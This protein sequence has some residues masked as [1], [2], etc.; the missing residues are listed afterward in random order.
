MSIISIEIIEIKC[1]KIRLCSHVIETRSPDTRVLLFSRSAQCPLPTTTTFLPSDFV[2]PFYN[3]PQTDARDDQQATFRRIQCS[4]LCTNFTRYKPPWSPQ[5]PSDPSEDNPICSQAA[6][7]SF[8]SVD[9]GHEYLYPVHPSQ[10]AF[11]FVQRVHSHNS[12]LCG[13]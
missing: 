2:I 13:E 4:R 7:V 3:G 5:P 9:P 12:Y 1:Q 11:A 10:L 6:A 8:F